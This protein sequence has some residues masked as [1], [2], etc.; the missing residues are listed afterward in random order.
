[1]PPKAIPL[2]FRHRS[3]LPDIISYLILELAAAGPLSLREKLILGMGT[4]QLPF[5][6][7]FSRAHVVQATQLQ[8]R[9]GEK[10][11]KLFLGL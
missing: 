5:V 11:P 8:K 10:T 7:F 6:S 9:W 4:A 3:A 2:R 1:M